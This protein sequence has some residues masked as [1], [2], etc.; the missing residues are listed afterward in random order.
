MVSSTRRAMMA[1]SLAPMMMNIIPVTYRRIRWA[2]EYWRRIRDR[3]YIPDSL[4]EWAVI[5]GEIAEDEYGDDANAVTERILEGYGNKL[6]GSG[7]PAPDYAT[8]FAEAKAKDTNRVKESI[9][10]VGEM[11]VE[12][13]R[14][15]GGL[16]ASIWG[17][18]Y[19]AA[20]L[21]SLVITDS[22]FDGPVIYIFN[23]DPDGPGPEKP[24]WPNDPSVDKFEVTLSMVN[25][26]I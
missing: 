16:S 8:A 23:V 14:F 10:A 25:S 4:Q 22:A 15:V 26:K 2:S 20:C 24:F 3:D 18:T 12:G 5:L 6:S 17:K 11:V 1:F 21:A 7:T 19:K 9:N 13:G